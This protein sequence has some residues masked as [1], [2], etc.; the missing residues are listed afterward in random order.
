MAFDDEGRRTHV[1]QA[2]NPKTLSCQV[3][4]GTTPDDPSYQLQ[5]RITRDQIYVD[6]KKA[7]DLVDG[8][9]PADH[10]VGSEYSMLI[11]PLRDA[12]SSRLTEDRDAP[13]YIL[14]A[15][16]TTDY[17]VMTQVV[18]T[19]DQAGW[20]A[21]EVPSAVISQRHDVRLYCDKQHIREI[22]KE[23]APRIRACYTNQL[24]ET[25]DLAG[26]VLSS[27]KIMPGGEVGKSSISESTL[28]NQDVEECINAVI[29][30]LEFDA[31]DGGVCVIHYPFVFN[32]E[33]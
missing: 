16:K 31:T 26:K 13:S 19:L 29:Q 32:I 3:S 17:R 14:V 28:N 23:A 9:V 33:E 1:C 2:T 5:V 27:F 25:P 30:T 12:L 22:I 4:S 20:L 8:R 24:A 15:D 18:Y 10:R 7:V 11:R 21:D 6:D